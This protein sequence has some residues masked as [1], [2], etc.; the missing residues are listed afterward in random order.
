MEPMTAAAR[1]AHHEPRAAADRARD[2]RRAAPRGAPEHGPELGPLVQRHDLVGAAEVPAVHE[3]PRRH[4]ERAAAAAA[5]ATVLPP[6]AAKQRPELLPVGRVHGDVALQ[7]RDAEAAEQAA[8]AGAVL[9][10][11]AHAAD[12]RRVQHHRALAAGRAPSLERIQGVRD[13]RPTSSSSSSAAGAARDAVPV[14]DVDVT[15]PGRVQGLR[16]GVDGAAEGGEEVRVEERRRG[17]VRP[18]VVR[19]AIGVL[20]LPEARAYVVVVRAELHLLGLARGGAWRDV[21]LV[22]IASAAGRGPRFIAQRRLLWRRFLEA[23]ARRRGR[24]RRGAGAGRERREEEVGRLRG[25]GGGEG[26]Q[27]PE[28][29]RSEPSHFSCHPSDHT[30]PSHT[31]ALWCDRHSDYFSV[32]YFLCC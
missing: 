7:E 9:E 12:R 15:A 28:D 30:L 23:D 14:V 10:R 13:A 1:A 27:G 5:A 6:P 22:V 24:L 20:L 26:L 2:L 4:G 16:V 21:L 29:P 18:A 19:G 3:Q 32:H 25:S 31:V 8:H 11:S 17:E